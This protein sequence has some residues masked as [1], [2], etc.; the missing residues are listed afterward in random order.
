M[1]PQYTGWC[2][3]SASSRLLPDA[4]GTSSLLCPRRLLVPPS[5]H[6]HALVDVVCCAPNLSG[7]VKGRSCGFVNE[8]SPGT[9]I[10]RRASPHNRS[11]QVRHR[12][13]TLIAARCSTFGPAVVATSSPDRSR[14]STRAQRP[15]GSRGALLVRH[16]CVSAASSVEGGGRHCDCAVDGGG[17][18]R[19]RAEK[20]GE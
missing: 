17:L 8:L 14:T 15:A 13:R 3:A 4:A 5:D 20:A 19:G 16:G 12:Y 18:R 1:A 2:L 7:R 10:G 9:P 11:P 6:M